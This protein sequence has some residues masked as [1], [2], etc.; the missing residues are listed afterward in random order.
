MQ[1]S[2]IFFLVMTT[3]PPLAA[4]GGEFRSARSG[5]DGSVEIKVFMGRYFKKDIC[6][7]AAWLPGLVS[8]FPIHETDGATQVQ[9]LDEFE[10][11]LTPK[12]EDVP[13]GG[14]S[15]FEPREGYGF[16][17]DEHH[18]VFRRQGYPE[19]HKYQDIADYLY[20][21][22]NLVMAKKTKIRNPQK[23]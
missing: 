15:T 5:Q 4:G 23:L 20:A 14:I 11:N 12:V 18:S 13:Q 2:S 21:K 22:T 17:V 10:A 3:I 6:F 8:K 1:L 7:S 19:D 16:Y 9:P